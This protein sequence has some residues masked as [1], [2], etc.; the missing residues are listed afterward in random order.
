MKVL[1]A[2]LRPGPQAVPARERVRVVGGVLLGLLLAG[3]LT[4]WAAP[5]AL[6]LAAP[7]GASA[8]LVFALPA[9]PL[10]Q[11]WAVL[12]GNTLSAVVG[13][14]LVQAGAGWAPAPLLAALAAALAVLLM[15]ATRCLHPPGGAVAVLAVVGGV[16]HWGFVLLPVALNSL[17]LL[18]AGVAYNRATGRPYPLQ[19]A[20]A[21][22]PG[23]TPRFT[24]ADLDRVLARQGQ[25]VPM[26]R[27]E[28]L[29]L[30]EAAETEAHRRRLG[31]LRCADIMSREVV[32]VE[33]G[34]PLQEAWT[35]MRSHRIKALPVLD[36]YRQ[37]LGIVT[38]A[39][40]MRHA[41]LDQHHD[42]PARLRALIRPT[43]GPQSDKAEVVGQIMTRRVRVASPQRTLAELVPILSATG[44]HHIPVVDHQRKL[45]GI[46]TQT[47]LV[48]ALVDEAGASPPVEDTGTRTPGP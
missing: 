4:R 30:L 24:D 25:V 10:S 2:S 26:S 29:P 7:L 8:V 3:G 20:P 28:L 40:F 43:P 46:L 36:R 31:A 1:M 39:D 16:S 34:T 35:L 48:R 14:A 18:A 32:T 11:P 12:A 37:V 44:H 38:L 27:E 6:W 9:G 17:L 42:F 45:L 33:F 5:Q 47:D 13:V 15:L 19:H 23:S 41:E 21:A 22:A